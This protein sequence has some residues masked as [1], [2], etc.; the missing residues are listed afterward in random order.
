MQGYP[1]VREKLGKEGVTMAKREL[2]AI[3]W[4]ITQDDH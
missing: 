3:D 1:A 4:F 2:R